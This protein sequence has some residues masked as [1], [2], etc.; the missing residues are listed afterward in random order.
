[1][2]DQ[3][4]KSE[5]PGVSASF[6]AGRG[7][8]ALLLR[9]A[10]RSLSPHI[11]SWRSRLAFF[12]RFLS[13]VFVSSRSVLSATIGGS[14]LPVVNYRLL[15]RIFKSH[16]LLLFIKHWAQKTGW[17][18]KRAVPQRISSRK[19]STLLSYSHLSSDDKRAP[20][21]RGHKVPSL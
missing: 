16:P 10:L 8:R 2:T 14:N 1:L 13:L 21:G 9:A 3:N 17:N 7:F 15:C 12:S 5:P 11:N 18:F 19:S 6:P 20:I 4:V